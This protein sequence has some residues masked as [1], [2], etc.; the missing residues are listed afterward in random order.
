MDTDIIVARILHFVF[1]VFWAGT[2]FFM[3]VILEPRL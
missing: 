3:A 1:G 2:A